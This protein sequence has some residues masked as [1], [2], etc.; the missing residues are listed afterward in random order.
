MHLGSHQPSFGDGAVEHR[1][2]RRIVLLPSICATNE[3]DG[4]PPVASYQAPS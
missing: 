2:P 3:C 1:L 4:S